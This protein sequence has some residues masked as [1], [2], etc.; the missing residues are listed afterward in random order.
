[1]PMPARVLKEAI[2]F[3]A[4]RSTGFCPV[5]AMKL[6]SI[7]S[8]CFG[9]Q[10]RPVPILTTTLRSLGAARALEKPNSFLSSGNA[11]FWY[12]SR[13]V[14]IKFLQLRFAFLAYALFLA[15]DNQDAYAR[16]GLASGT[17]NHGRHAHRHPDCRR[18]EK[19]RMQEMQSG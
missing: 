1:M 5:I 16:G 14:I 6:F 4:F 9:S 13:I 7:V 15:A 8:N 17:N 2:A 3:L 10:M 11:T 12:R 19:A 18:R